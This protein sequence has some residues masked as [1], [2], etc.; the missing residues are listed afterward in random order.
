MDVDKL[1]WTTSRGLLIRRCGF[2]SHPRSLGLTSRGY[3]SKRIDFHGVPGSSRSVAS[4]EG[5]Y[6]GRPSRRLLGDLLGFERIAREEVGLNS[7]TTLH[8]ARRVRLR[9]RLGLVTEV[10]P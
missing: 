1:P 9:E 4:V 6:I 8:D 10:S 5:M 7:W 3:A 2:E